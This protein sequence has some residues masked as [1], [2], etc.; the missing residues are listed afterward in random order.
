MDRISYALGWIGGAAT[1]Y[2]TLA[3]GAIG[4]V[5]ATTWMLRT[6]LHLVL[7]VRTR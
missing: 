3:L 1:M 6:T 2:W 4:A 7:G 5:W